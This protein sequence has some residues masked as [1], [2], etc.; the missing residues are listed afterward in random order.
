MCQGQK[1]AVQVALCDRGDPGC[2]DPGFCIEL[3]CFPHPVNWPLWFCGV[4]CFI[5]FLVRACAIVLTGPKAQFDAAQPHVQ[6]HSSSF[7]AAELLE[8]T[9]VNF[10]RPLDLTACCHSPPMARHIQAILNAQSAGVSDIHAWG[11]MLPSSSRINP[12]TYHLVVEVR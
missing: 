9:M 10:P 1:N 11:L 7:L 6:R 2:G 12:V 8:G 3:C 5:C 4:S